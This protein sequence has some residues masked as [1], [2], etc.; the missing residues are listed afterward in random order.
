MRRTRA[1]QADWLSLSPEMRARIT[2]YQKLDRM[3]RKLLDSHG[4]NRWRFCIAMDGEMISR[5]PAGSTDPA[6]SDA[7]GQC[8]HDRKLIA[9]HGKLVDSPRVAK[10]VILHE[11]AHVLVRRRYG[12]NGDDNHGRKFCKLARKLGCRTWD[13]LERYEFTN[14]LKEYPEMLEDPVLSKYRGLVEHEARENEAIKR[15][16]IER[17]KRGDR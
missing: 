16:A 12:K 13:Q 14:M 1:Q 7:F 2:A 9:I 5:D 6:G 11:I 3:G 10:Q 15:A 4:L 8:Q 17:E